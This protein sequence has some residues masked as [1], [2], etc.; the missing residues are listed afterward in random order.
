MGIAS[1][2]SDSVPN[3]TF[4]PQ[5]PLVELL[6]VSLAKDAVLVMASAQVQ[7]DNIFK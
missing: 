5:E 6:K 3:I 2:A 4:T 1:L 7:I